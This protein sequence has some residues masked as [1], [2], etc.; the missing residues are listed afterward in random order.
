MIDYT[1]FYKSTLPVDSAWGSNDRWDLYI[2]AY[3]AA[4]RLR[5]VYERVNA[6]DKW[7]LIFPEYCFSQSE[8]PKGNVFAGTSKDEANFI[9]EFWAE[10]PRK[11]AEGR[12]CV[13]ITGFIRPYLMFLLRWFVEQKVRKF[14][15]IYSEPIAY[16]K[17]EETKF[18]DEVVEQVRQV[19]GFEGNHLTDIS[20]DVLIIGSGYNTP[21]KLG[22]PLRYFFDL[23]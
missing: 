20:H 22:A 6:S 8:F 10:L 1:I 5:H 23:T 18:S 7:W 17:R 15:A 19:A 16:A 11:A 21:Q 13:D 14:D 3:T 12:I 4:E 9:R 2:S